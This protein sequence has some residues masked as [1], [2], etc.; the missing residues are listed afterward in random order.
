L[1]LV[2]F[3][4]AQQQVLYFY[5]L[6]KNA[7]QNIEIRTI[8]EWISRTLKKIFKLHHEKGQFLFHI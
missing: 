7:K 8:R 2:L 3:W 6:L 1:P 4:F 5:Q